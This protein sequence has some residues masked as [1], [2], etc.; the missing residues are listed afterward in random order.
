MGTRNSSLW[1]SAI[2]IFCFVAPVAATEPLASVCTSQWSSPPPAIETG[3]G[4]GVDRIINEPVR[5]HGLLVDLKAPDAEGKS[6]RF[7]YDKWARA[8]RKEKVIYIEPDKA[9][10]SSSSQLSHEVG[11]AALSWKPD[12]SSRDAYIRSSCLDEGAALAENIRTREVVKQCLGADIHL[13]SSEEDAMTD[14]YY[15]LQSHPPLNLA[16][17]GYFFCERNTVSGSGKS[18]IDYY[19]EHYD[20]VIGE[21]RL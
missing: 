12:W 17:L 6:W 16:E 19:G 8:D 20:H 4:D 13:A 2:T 7:Q 3:Y 1:C 5:M 21:V 18:Y 11:H 10:I 15:E 14:K 9:D